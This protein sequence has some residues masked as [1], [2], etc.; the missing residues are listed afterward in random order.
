[1]DMEDGVI[2]KAKASPAIK[3][4]CVTMSEG[5]HPRSVYRAGVVTRIRDKIG[6]A[7]K[8]VIPDEV[9]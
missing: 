8:I 2:Q 4:D 9:W 5:E 1:M 6:V 3:R 7:D